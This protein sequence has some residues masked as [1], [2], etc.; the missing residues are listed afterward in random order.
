MSRR[1]KEHRQRRAI[2]AHNFYVDIFSIASC[3]FGQVGKL[4]E[5][6]AYWL[7][8]MCPKYSPAPTFSH[9]NPA[10]PMVQKGPKFPRYCYTLVWTNTRKSV[11]VGVFPIFYL[12]RNVKKKQCGV[13]RSSVPLVFNKL[14][15]QEKGLHGPSESE[16]AQ[17]DKE[18]GICQ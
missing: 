15:K 13:C 3:T 9:R 10:N 6:Q 8:P 12:L 18:R 1:E 7:P 2:S 17:S 11:K 16:R 5:G 14:L 4:H